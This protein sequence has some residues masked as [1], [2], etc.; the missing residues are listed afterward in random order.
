MI[1][2]HSQQWQWPL[3]EIQGHWYSI[4]AA[5]LTRY[6]LLI[7][8]MATPCTEWVKKSSPEVFWHFFPKWLGIFWPNFTS[9]LHVHVYDRLPIFIQLTATLM[10]LCRIKRDH[11]PSSHH[12]R[13]ISTIDRNAH[14]NFLT[15]LPRSWESP[16]FTCLLYVPIYARIQIFIQLSPTVM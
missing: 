16:N 11:P 14:W 1:L 10:K 2:S 12:K 3:S 4:N 8:S 6:C 15:F 5:K 9:L 13:K 7:P